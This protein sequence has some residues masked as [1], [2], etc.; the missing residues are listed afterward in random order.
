MSMKY[1]LGIIG[2]AVVV[3]GLLCLMKKYNDNKRIND[4]SNMK[5]NEIKSIKD[6]EEKM[7]VDKAS[8]SE[9]ISDRHKEANNIMRKSV[10]SIFE[11]SNPE[12]TK[13]DEIKKKISDDLD[14]L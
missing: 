9:R 12:V 10:D 1:V 7:I 14:N 3:G 2:T 4:S 6:D 8:S 13:N 5:S 11:D